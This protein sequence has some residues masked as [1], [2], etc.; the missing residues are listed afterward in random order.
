M[1]FLVDHP[2]VEESTV[3]LLVERFRQTRQP[4]VIPTFEGRRGHPVL[5]GRTVFA[6]LFSAPLQEGARF[7]VRGRPEL[8]DTVEVD[9]PG[10]LAD[11]DTPE[12]Y[13]NMT[14]GRPNG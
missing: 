11:I 13:E 5:F 10:I 8:V 3:A 9:D 12:Q 6:E 2:L 1:V 4:I 14:R 7:V